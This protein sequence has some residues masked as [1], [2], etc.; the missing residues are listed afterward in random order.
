MAFTSAIDSCARAG[1]WLNAERV[2]G[3]MIFE[4]KV[5][6]NLRTYRAACKAAAAAGEFAKCEGLLDDVKDGVGI[7][8]QAPFNSWS[9]AVGVR[10]CSLHA[11]A[12]ISR[13]SCPSLTG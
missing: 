13:R 5:V 11:V 6:P 4:D 7:K 10:S 1:D 2:L 12:C 9:L 3:Q 8:V